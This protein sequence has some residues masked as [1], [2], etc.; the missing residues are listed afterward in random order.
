M[1]DRKTRGMLVLGLLND[2][3]GDVRTIIYYLN[4]FRLSH[5]EMEE[6]KEFGLDEVIDKAIEL[7]DA[8]LKNMERIKAEIY[9]E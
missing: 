5:P 1:F 6:I 7:Q 2:A 9:K 8:I 4:D 3:Y